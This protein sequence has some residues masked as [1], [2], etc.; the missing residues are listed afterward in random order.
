MQTV[1]TVQVDY[2]QYS[3]LTGPVHV[4]MYVCTYVCMYVCMYVC[5]VVSLT[6][7]HP[8]LQKALLGGV[9]IGVNYTRLSSIDG[10]ASRV[11]MF[12]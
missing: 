5:I 4:C 7:D 6:V 1:Y 11:C 8:G 2:I 10:M 3:Q 12:W 9:G